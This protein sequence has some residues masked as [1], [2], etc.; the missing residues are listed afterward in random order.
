MELMTAEDAI[1]RERD[2]VLFTRDDGTQVGVRIRA[3][4]LKDLLAGGGM[5]PG[6][7]GGIVSTPEERLAET[8]RGFATFCRAGVVA[9]EAFVDSPAWA[10]LALQYKQRIA[11]AIT[12]LSGFGVGEDAANADTFP[13]GDGR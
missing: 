4:D 13:T 1:P 2:V 6:A 9:P 8:E 12:A 10:G 3:I 11:D 5:L 7:G